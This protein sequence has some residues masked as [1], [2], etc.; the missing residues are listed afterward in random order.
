MPNGIEPVSNQQIRWSYWYLTHRE[1]LKR[2]LVIALIVLCV[3]FWG[4][5]II[6]L[7]Y[8]LLVE[9]P[10]TQEAVTG[11]SRDGVRARDFLQTLEDI[12]I[13]TTNVFS[14]A[15]THTDFYARIQ[16]PNREYAALSFTYTFTYDG[17]ETPARQGYLLPG[18]EMDL[19]A[20]GLTNVESPRNPQLLITSVQWKRI[21]GWSERQRTMLD[22]PVTDIAVAPIANDTR[23]GTAVTFMLTNNTTYSF[24]AIDV[25][26]VLLQGSRVLGV[27]A[28]RLENVQ[29]AERRPVTLQWFGAPADATSVR[30]APQVNV[31][32]ASVIQSVRGGE[33]KF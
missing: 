16:N 14:T 20:L 11:L 23:G 2:A 24:W 15:D 6:R 25:P 28:I 32:D 13:V 5:S 22:L 12:A 4:Y 29:S 10:R 3:V 7:T 33:Q 21:L 31:L 18:A 17:G 8:L 30:V 27:N 9:E 1:S 26:I 19:Y